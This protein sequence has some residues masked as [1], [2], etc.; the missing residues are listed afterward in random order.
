MNRIRLQPEDKFLSPNEHISVVYLIA[1]GVPECFLALHSTAHFNA[2]VPCPSL[3]QEGAL[4]SSGFWNSSLA[5]L[6]PR[7]LGMSFPWTYFHGEMIVVTVQENTVVTVQVQLE[8]ALPVTL[9]DCTAV[10]CLV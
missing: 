3:L 8:S 1:Y 4:I 7:L 5:A 10:L 6:L 9:H 2:A